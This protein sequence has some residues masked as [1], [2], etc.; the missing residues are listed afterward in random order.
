MPLKTLLDQSYVNTNIHT[1][2]GKDYPY[3]KTVWNSVVADAVWSRPKPLPLRDTPMVITKRRSNPGI[4]S[5]GPPFNHRTGTQIFC[6]YSTPV[7][8]EE[9]G[10]DGSG[11]FNRAL[12]GF[13]EFTF[14]E[15]LV[16]GKKTADTFLKRGRQLDAI[17]NA[18]LRGD[19]R[20]LERALGVGVRD[21]AWRNLTSMTAGQRIANGYNEVSYGILPALQAVGD[22]ARAYIRG[23]GGRGQRRRRTRGG[24]SWNPN[25]DGFSNIPAPQGSGTVSGTIRNELLANANML[26]LLNVPQEVWNYV[27]YSFVFDWMIPI[28]TYLGGITATAGLGEVRSC[29]TSVLRTEQYQVID[30]NR[31]YCETT[32]RISRTPQIAVPMLSGLAHGSA[33]T[34]GKVVS[35]LMLMRAR[36]G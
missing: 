17:G 7:R 5:S 23:L 13:Q 30:G 19:R 27:P 25:T 26:G 32:E 22:T 1:V 3:T 16:E 10:D 24:N 20:A 33:M 6:Y 35:S 29:R 2:Y 9:R 8:S 12:A 15:T 21:G 18:L 11:A 4:Y 36:Y 34:F 28:G 14:G 31:L